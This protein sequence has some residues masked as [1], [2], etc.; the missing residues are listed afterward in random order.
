MTVR[1]ASGKHGGV[2]MNAGDG[3]AFVAGRQIADAIEGVVNIPTSKA[4][5]HHSNL[6]RH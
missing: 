6:F 4:H 3:P 5:E 1:R 2:E